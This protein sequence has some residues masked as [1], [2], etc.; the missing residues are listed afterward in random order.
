MVGLL[1]SQGCVHPV[2]HRRVRVAVLAVGDQLVAPGEAPVLH[3]ERNAAGLTVA[4]PCIQWGAMV[5]DLGTVP[6]ADLDRALYRATTAPVVLVMGA[7][8]AAISDAL[9]RA[10][11][12]VRVSGISLDPCDDLTYG[13][14][15]GESG[16]VESHVFRLSP[17]P[18]A[19]LVAATLLV[20]PLVARLQG[21]VLA[22]PPRYRRAVWTETQ[23]PT[24]HRTRAVPVKIDAGDDAQIRALPISY[25]GVDDLAGFAQADALAL[26]PP[27]GGPWIGGELVEVVPIGQAFHA[28]GW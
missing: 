7:E 17:S 8:S 27:H 5:H 2:C 4:I 25:R 15:R 18:V 6:L 3:R 1:A 12:E 16:R 28:A 22:D 11:L 19:A 24:D 14:I 9:A 21:E 10:G 20:A 26:F 13:V 23:G